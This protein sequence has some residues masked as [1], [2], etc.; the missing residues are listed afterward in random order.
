MRLYLWCALMSSLY[1][2]PCTGHSVMPRNKVHKHGCT[3]VDSVPDVLLEC[4]PGEAW[5][6]AASS[7][8]EIDGL[9]E[10]CGGAHPPT[11]VAVENLIDYED[12]L[13]F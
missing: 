4:D 11:E 8:T 9:S 3:D 7:G 1:S 13:S 5:H 2:V 6:A 12:L 10:H